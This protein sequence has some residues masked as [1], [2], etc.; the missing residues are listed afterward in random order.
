MV[1]R[2]IT[3][4]TVLLILS[5]I[6]SLI[7]I[8]NRESF[9]ADDDIAS[10]I[11]AGGVNWRITADESGGQYQRVCSGRRFDGQRNTLRTPGH[12]LG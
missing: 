3:I 1:K 6:V 8:L 2:T 10:G 7:I 9:A 4:T 5:M 12:D 11:A